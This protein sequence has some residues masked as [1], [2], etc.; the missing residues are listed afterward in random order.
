MYENMLW[1]E[2]IPAIGEIAYDNL[3]HI[4]FQQDSAADYY[5]Q[6]V[7][8]Y[9]DEHFPNSWIPGKCPIKYPARSPDLTQRALFLWGCLKSQEYETMI[10]I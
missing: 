10:K 3:K 5:G 9:L 4:W 6:N 1:N 7:N 2:I 8:N